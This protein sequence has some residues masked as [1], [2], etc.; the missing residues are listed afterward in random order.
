MIFCEGYR[1][2]SEEKEIKNE[3]SNIIQNKNIQ[4]N[5]NDKSLQTPNI[6]NLRKLRLKFYQTKT[7]SP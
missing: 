4:G 1:L 7:I 3:T 5:T 6:A 2:G